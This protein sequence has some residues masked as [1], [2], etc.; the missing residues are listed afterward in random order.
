MKSSMVDLVA[1]L[2]V[3][4]PWPAGWQQVCHD[5]SYRAAGSIESHIRR[6]ARKST[7]VAVRQLWH[8]CRIVGLA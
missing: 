5:P 6:S 8:G 4:R 3:E 2:Q 7:A 1:N